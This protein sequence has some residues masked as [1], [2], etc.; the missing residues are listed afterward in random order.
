MGCLCLLWTKNIVSM[1]STDFSIVSRRQE[2]A[3]V[4]MVRSVTKRWRLTRTAFWA[5]QSIEGLAQ[6]PIITLTRLHLIGH[7]PQTR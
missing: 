1:S 5:H 7:E 4:L 2:L 6:Q 3:Q